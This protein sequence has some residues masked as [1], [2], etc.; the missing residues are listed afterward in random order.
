M[1]VRTCPS[2]PAKKRGPGV[3]TSAFDI[4]RCKTLWHLAHIRCLA[5]GQRLCRARLLDVVQ[6]MYN[7]AGLQCQLT[8]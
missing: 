8:C 1:A 4:T 7:A 2:L 3:T 6:S 5:A